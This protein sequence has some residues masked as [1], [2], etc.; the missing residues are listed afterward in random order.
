[1]DRWQA[2]RRIEEQHQ[3]GGR[4]IECGP[5]GGCVVLLAA[6]HRRIDQASTGTIRT[7]L[8]RLV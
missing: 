8:G 5:R 2:D 7:G 1:M 6:V 3:D 4:C